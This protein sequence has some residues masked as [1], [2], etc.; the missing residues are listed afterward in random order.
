MANET[1]I[2]EYPMKLLRIAFLAVAF[3]SMPGHGPAYAGGPIQL[4]QSKEHC[5][6]QCMLNRETCQS[7]TSDATDQCES[8][9]DNTCSKCTE[10]MDVDTLEQCNS[11]CNQCKSQCDTVAESRQ[12]ACDASQDKC[13]GKCMGVD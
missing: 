10:N 6:T 13:L 4:A 2:V 7:D 8:D 1:Q 9:C 3:W 5:E 12:T 11:Q